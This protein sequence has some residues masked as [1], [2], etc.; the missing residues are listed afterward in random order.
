MWGGLAILGGFI[1]IGLPLPITMGLLGLLGLG[2]ILLIEPALAIIL[3]LVVAPLKTLIETEL[4]W[5]L[6]LDIGQLSFGLVVGVW[7]FKKILQ[8]TNL[9]SH[10]RSPLFIPLLLF[11]LITGF[12]L[13][14][15]YSLSAGL[16]EWLKWTEMVVLVAIALDMQAR[17]QWLVFGVILAGVIQAL[18]GIYEFQGGSGA[19]HL[20]ILDYQYFR[21]FG[22]FGQPNPFGAFMGLVLPLAIGTTWGYLTIAWQKWQSAPSQIRLRWPNLLQ[23]ILLNASLSLV[24]VVGLLVSWSRGAWLGFGVAGSVILWLAPSQRKHGN[25]AVA[26]GGLSFGFLWLLGLLPAAITDRILSFTEDFRGFGDMR[27][28]VISDEN[29]AVVERLA[30]WQTALDM[31]A[32]RPLLGV[33]F[34]NYEAA[35]P[36]FALV[37]WEFALGHAHNYYIN[38]LAETGV[39]GLFVYLLLWLA[40]FGWTWQTLQRSTGIERGVTLGLMGVWVHLSIHSLVDKLYVNNLFLHIGIM[41]GLLAI[42]HQKSKLPKEQED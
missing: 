22:T 18:V 19:A 20:W 42:L 24:I 34:G 7:L 41:L 16:R 13:P 37:N 8:R 12:S 6:P 3:M 35:Y 15:A 32:H 14:A 36:D 1:V 11:L 28:V 17:W 29:F 40:I 31:A 25:I 5:P 4:S 33:G 2:F 26:L 10:I 39:L 9:S 27:G 21:A 23:L 30:H 38:L